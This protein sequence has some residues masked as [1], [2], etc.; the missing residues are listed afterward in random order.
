MQNSDSRLAGL[1]RRFDNIASVLDGYGN[2]SQTMTSGGRVLHHQADLL[3]RTAR[4]ALSYRWDRTSLVGEP[5]R[6]KLRRQICDDFAAVLLE[7]GVALLPALEGTQ[8]NGVPI[9]L[10]AVLRRLAVNAG[11]NNGGKIVLYAS[12]LLNYS[13]ERH[14]DPVATLAPQLAPGLPVSS[15]GEPFLFLRIPRVER[16]SALL[17]TILAGHE[18]GHLRDWTNRL[19]LLTPPI[20]VPSNWL[21]T[22]GAI[23][24]EHAGSLARFTSVA[25]RWAGEIVADIVGAL[26]FGPAS[27]NALSELVGTLGSWSFDSETHP[28]TDRRIALLIDLMQREHFDTIPEVADLLD[29]FKAETTTALTRT[30]AIRNTPDLVADQAA[31]NLVLS[32]RSDLETACRAAIRDDEIF[33]TSDWAAVTAAADRLAAGQ[34]CGESFDSG[35]DLIAERDSVIMNA[36][37]KVRATTLSTLGSLLGLDASTAQDASQISAVLDELVLKSFEVAEYRRQEPWI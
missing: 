22:T 24:L 8:S 13:I 16:D 7:L 6:E 25:N 11:G 9:E 4:D 36:A 35:G 17:H 20:I 34:P 27:L 2:V 23:K 30:V 5:Q 18:L 26:T 14:P 10:E 21:D 3:L 31:W 15:T 37:Y 1:H 19:S 29:H 32:K 33:R 12:E 28:G